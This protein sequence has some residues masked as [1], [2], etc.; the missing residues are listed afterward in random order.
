MNIQYVGKNRKPFSETL[1]KYLT[2][3]LIEFPCA[4]TNTDLPYKISAA[5]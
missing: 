3:A 5:I 1:S 4:T 2:M